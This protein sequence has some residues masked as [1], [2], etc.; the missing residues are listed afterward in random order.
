MKYVM[1]NRYLT[2]VLIRRSMCEEYDMKV[3]MSDRSN[4]KR[5]VLLL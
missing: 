3:L 2:N 1:M 5:R 4:N